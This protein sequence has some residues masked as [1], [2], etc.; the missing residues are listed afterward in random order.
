MSAPVLSPLRTDHLF[1][2]AVLKVF[3]PAL[4]DFATVAGVCDVTWLTDTTMHDCGPCTPCAP[5]PT[6]V[7]QSP[8]VRFTL[9]AV[10]SPWLYQTLYGWEP[11]TL[12]LGPS[13]TVAAEVVTLD[14]LLTS[15]QYAGVITHQNHAAPTVTALSISTAAGALLVEGVHYTVGVWGGYTVVVPLPGSGLAQGDEL[16]VDYAFTPANEIKL[17]PPTTGLAPTRAWQ[18]CEVVPALTAGQ[19]QADL[20]TLTLD[21]GAVTSGVAWAWPSCCPGAELPDGVPVT[22]T[23]APGSRWCAQWQRR[24]PL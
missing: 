21:Q 24:Y 15:E 6:I 22:V 8:R 3:D 23:A 13:L 11:T 19:S 5:A 1:S 7:T 4:D 14:H 20:L 18:L 9:H 2:Q 16:L 12:D 10:R 17:S